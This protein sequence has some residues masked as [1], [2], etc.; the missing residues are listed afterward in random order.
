MPDP[1]DP[2]HETAPPTR[3]TAAR[4][5][6]IVSDRLEARAAARDSR[7]LTGPPPTTTSAPSPVVPPP[8]GPAQPTPPADASVVDL[9]GI[10]GAAIESPPP[11]DRAP[12]LRLPP[13]APGPTAVPPPAALGPGGAVGGPIGPTTRPP[14]RLADLPGSAPTVAAE[15]GMDPPIPAASAGGNGLDPA[16]R[17]DGIEVVTP[18]VRGRLPAAT[19]NLALASAG[20]PDRGSAG[21]AGESQGVADDRAGFDSMMTSARDAVGGAAPELAQTN[22]LLQQILDAI[23]KQGTTDGS[24]LPAGGPPVYAERI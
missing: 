24:S 11:L 6:R 15:D 3:A 7:L 22:D 8:S 2:D 1:L 18:G 17:G 16:A 23:R 5:A 4:A 21:S 9:E 20:P 12:G 10:A 14:G 13:P 19:A